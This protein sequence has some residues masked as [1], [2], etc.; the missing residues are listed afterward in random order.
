MEAPKINIP[1]NLIS[2][3][4]NFSD[5]KVCREYLEHIIWDGSPTCPH[6]GHGKYYAFKDGKTYKCASNK[7]NLKYN[8]KIGTFLEGTKLP[9]CKWLHALYVFTSHK[10]GISS[11]Q[12]G[13]DLGIT[14][15]SAWFMLSRIREILREK[16][17]LMVSGTVEIDE[18]YYGGLERNKHK[19]KIKRRSTGH[20]VDLKI[21]ILGIVQRGGKAMLI[22]IPDTTDKVI[23]PIIEKSVV[24]GS[25][26][27]TDTANVYKRLNDNFWHKS[28]NHTTGEYVRERWHTNTV[29]GLFSH[30]KRGIYGI[31]HHASPKHLEKYCNEFSFRYNTRK[32]KEVERFDI[33]IRQSKGRLTYAN[34][35]KKVV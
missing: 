3:S 11:H 10:K 18:T 19:S 2:L 27:V 14:Q 6:C 25:W 7:C 21:P 8:I 17:P 9:L 22:P 26:I 20:A 31:Y 35:I 23:H 29:E 15:K 1:I 32:C 5:E 34:L 16:A 4:K 33:A 13:R 30:I 24:Q 12:L 28:I